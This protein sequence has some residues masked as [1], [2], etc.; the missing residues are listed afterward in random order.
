MAREVLDTSRV[1]ADNL[2]THLYTRKLPKLYR[3]ADISVDYALKRYLQTLIEGGYLHVISD[4]E[5]LRQLVNPISCPAEFFPHLYE[6]FGL[7]YYPDIDIKYH[8]RF[9]SNF[10]EIMRR[11]GTYSCIDYL[12]RTVT[13]IPVTLTYTRTYGGEPGRYLIVTLVAETMAQLEGIDTSIQVIQ[14]F[15]GDFIPYYIT[16]V[17]V[18]QVNSQ[19]LSNENH[20]YGGAM[21]VFYSYSI[22]PIDTP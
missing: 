22:T 4:A 13:G 6:S 16:P 2:L 3:D 15:I 1:Y 20:L 7:T 19:Y 9:L 17:V 5:R 18:S 8:R 10:G 14:R 21:Q 11:R 12:V